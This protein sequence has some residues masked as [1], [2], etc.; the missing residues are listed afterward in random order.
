[1]V[2]H[3]GLGR[4]PKP[5]LGLQQLPFASQISF[6]N[7]PPLGEG[8]RRWRN[9]RR[10]CWRFQR[11]STFLALTVLHASWR[12]SDLSREAWEVEGWPC[13]RA[14]RKRSGHP[15]ITTDGLRE[16]IQSIGMG[17][18]V[19]LPQT[20][21][22]EPCQ[23]QTLPFCRHQPLICVHWHEPRMIRSS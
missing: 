17:P 21:Q 11:C 23:I 13:S 1:M 18:E 22:K 19:G 15:R 16:L 12:R 5:G 8:G 20:A 2:L 7:K 4:T 10:D 3:V 9:A 14:A 6:Q